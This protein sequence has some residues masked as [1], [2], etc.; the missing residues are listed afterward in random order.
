MSQA[1][2]QKN[3]KFYVSANFLEISYIFNWNHCEIW[4]EGLNPQNIHFLG[5]RLQLVINYFQL[6]TL[7]DCLKSKPDVGWYYCRRSFTICP[8]MGANGNMEA[9]TTGWICQLNQLKD[10]NKNYREKLIGLKNVS[11]RLLHLGSWYK[12]GAHAPKVPF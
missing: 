5:T 9:N 2:R 11:A 7:T 10:L 8:Q 3:E 12:T 6:I 1:R 4:Q